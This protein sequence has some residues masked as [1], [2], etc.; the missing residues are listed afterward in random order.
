MHRMGSTPDLSPRNAS[1]GARTRSCKVWLRSMV[2]VRLSFNSARSFRG[3]QRIK[4][5]FSIKTVR[6]KIDSVQDAIQEIRARPLDKLRCAGLDRS[7]LEPLYRCLSRRLWRMRPSVG[8]EVLFAA[9]L[10]LGAECEPVGG[11]AAVCGTRNDGGTG[12]L[13]PS[14][15]CWRRAPAPV[16]ST[17]Y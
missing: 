5:L 14:P 6:C 13:P 15:H 17:H 3:P 4:K 9:N 1:S 11:W 16:S 7:V 2:D 12:P 10:R 8:K